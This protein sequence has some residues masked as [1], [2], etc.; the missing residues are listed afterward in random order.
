MGL[1]LLL[2]VLAVIG[3][4]K[5]V[6]R[7]DSDDADL[8]RLLGGLDRRW[9]R[10]AGVRLCDNLRDIPGVSWSEFAALLA[11]APEFPGEVD[12]S[13]FVLSSS[14]RIRRY[15]RRSYS[16]FP[17]SY[18]YLPLSDSDMT[19]IHAF[20]P[21]LHGGE[22]VVALIPGLLFDKSGRRKSFPQDTFSLGFGGLPAR[23]LTRIGVSWSL[24]LSDQPLA[25][26]PEVDFIVTERG[27]TEV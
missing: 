26:A 17:P 6:K 25:G 4:F 9:C 22:R 8:L 18:W 10:T 23:L 12:L 21:E 27:V 2:M 14:E 16:D 7:M 20:K 15:L 19:T 3:E 11:S 1:Y 13:S 5:M 24:Q